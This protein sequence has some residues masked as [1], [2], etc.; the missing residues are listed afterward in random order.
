LQAVGSF[1][2]ERHDVLM[3]KMIIKITMKNLIYYLCIMTGVVIVATSCKDDDDDSVIQPEPD[4]LLT[5]IEQNGVTR[6]EF[7]YDTDGKITRLNYYTNGELASYSLY[8]YN[9]QGPREV[10]R[11]QKNHSLDY[12]YVFTLDNFGRVIKSEH[13]TAQSDF[14]E[15]SSLS[16]FNYDPSGQLIT[17]QFS[18]AGEPVYYRE[19]FTYGASHHPVKMKKTHYPNQA[20]EYV[21]GLTEYTFSEKTI[22][23][24]WKDYVFLLSISGFDSFIWE[25]F[26]SGTHFKAWYDDG[27]VNVWSQ[28][29]ATE[30]EYNSNGYLIRQV[31]TRQ[32]L[33]NP[34][35]PP[36]VTEMT[37]EYTEFNE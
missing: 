28:T 11:Y 12:K 30:R 36:T 15:V 32:S 7:S 29:D 27:E 18:S 33:S 6:A 5:R 13:Y 2:N 14:E 26:N 4:F 17:K 37:Y 34:A 1:S 31:L 24:H 9:D 20:N 8:E 25:M 10:R 3:T 16:T 23:D 21:A 35:L 22:Y 19:E